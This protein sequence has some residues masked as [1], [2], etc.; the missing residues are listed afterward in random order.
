[1]SGRRFAAAALLLVTAL[2]GC[3]HFSLFGELDDI[4]DATVSLRIVPSSAIVG[5]SATYNFVAIGGSPPYDFELFSGVGTVTVINAT[6]ARYTAPAGETL[7]IVRLIDAKGTICD[8]RVNVLVPQVLTLNPT[9]MTLQ[10]SASYAF[11]GLGG[12]PP[13]SYSV[14][15]PASPAGGVINAGTGLY[16][17]PASDP[18]TVTLRV[19]DGMGAW[20]DASVEI[21]SSGAIG[22]S[23][24]AATVEQGSSLA[25]SGYGGTPGYTYAVSGGSGAATINS[26][27]G[28]F[29][30]LAT[31]V[32][33][34]TYTV[35]VTD[36]VLGT[37]S[38]TVTIAPA[39]PTDLVANGSWPGPQDILLT[40]VDNAIGETGYEIW[41]KQGPG[42]FLLIH[43]TAADET[44]YEV[45]GLTP[46]LPYTYKV[47]AVQSGIPIYSSFSELAFDIP[48][49]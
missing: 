35:T 49:S 4:I 13:Y 17:A 10:V 39:A 29:T 30:A 2:T 44:S 47:R 20:S 36:T 1:M 15:N 37:A 6:T 45:T 46:N 5:T 14:F 21:V 25:F 38:A 28:L 22:I 41:Q 27:S 19:T 18:G 8:A 33:G 11:Y 31:A 43:T 48:N 16:T 24:A 9:S 34:E 3:D 7:D 42:A 12:T 32:P 26:G 40:W 23:P